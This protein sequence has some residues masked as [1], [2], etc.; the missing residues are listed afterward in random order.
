VLPEP[1]RGELRLG[2][3]RGGQKWPFLTT[4]TEPDY[5]DTAPLPPAGQSAVWKYRAIYL[6]DDQPAGQWSEPATIA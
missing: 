6:L 5:L 2:P 3:V 1:G 4:D